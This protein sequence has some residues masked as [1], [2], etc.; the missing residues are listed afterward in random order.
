MKQLASFG[1]YSG[2]NS[3]R[4]WDASGNQFWFSYKTLVAFRVPSGTAGGRVCRQNDWGPTTG[5]H[6][7]SIEPDKSKRVDAATFERLYAEAFK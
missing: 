5:R 7:N 4:F 3:L 2:P 1:S 6:L